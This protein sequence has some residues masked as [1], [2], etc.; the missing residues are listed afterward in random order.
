MTVFEKL[1]NANDLP[2]VH[3]ANVFLRSEYQAHLGVNT[4]HAGARLRQLAAEGKV[5]KV[6]TRRAGKLVAAWEYVGKTPKK[7][8]ASE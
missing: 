8:T 1:A 5:R 3:G 2:I 7:V 6:R 4:A